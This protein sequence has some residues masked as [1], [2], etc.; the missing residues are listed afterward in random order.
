M[1]NAATINGANSSEPV[2]ILLIGLG[3]I[4]SVYAYLL[5][6]SGK[7][8]VTA[9]ARSNYTLYTT[10]GVTLHTD[11][12]G[13]VEGWK[14]Y[15]VVRS[16]AEALA[17]EKR[18]AICVVCTKCL[19]D[20][21]PN[22]ELLKDAIESGQIGSWNLVQNGLGI[23]EDLYQA[24]KHLGTPVMSSPA[25]IGIVTEGSLVRWRG[26]DTLVTGLY[27][28]LP[29]KDK[30]AE[31]E[32]RIF[33]AREKDALKLWVDLLTAGEG[34]VHPTDHIDSIRFLKNVWNCA[35]AVVT[36]LIRHTALQFSYLGPTEEKYIKDYFMEIVDIGFK[37]GLLYE[38]MI[39]YP[40]GDVMGDAQSV[41]NRAWTVLTGTARER[42]VGHKYSLLI[43]VEQ[44][45]PF[46]VEVIVGS[47][48]N[49]AKKNNLVTPRLEFAYAMLKALQLE[50]IRDNDR[51]KVQKADEVGA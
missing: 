34:Y 20:V 12:F 25:W 40:A 41:V 10:T 46:E 28:P 15:R 27:P 17:D 19:P 4:G 22:S 44:N 29:P 48:L 8:R 24:V 49:I 47:V 36:G 13:I 50:I 33:T 43:D 38:G 16:Q 14:P 9:V 30:P 1:T 42:G 39:Q 45:R 21:L 11:R 2:D 32:A 3:S 37:T 26:K 51:K 23:E 35:W 6:R 7:A 5:E 31:G 18:Y